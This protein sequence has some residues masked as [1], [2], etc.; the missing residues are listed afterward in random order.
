[1][2]PN[3][4]IDARCIWPRHIY[5]A[6]I[7]AYL[8][9]QLTSCQQTANIG[10]AT[11]EVTYPNGAK[12]TGTITEKSFFTTQYDSLLFGLSIGNADA[13]QGTLEYEFLQADGIDS[14]K[15]IVTRTL[16]LSGA[17]MKVN[18]IQRIQTP[19]GEF[20][21]DLNEVFLMSMEKKKGGGPGPGRCC[22]PAC[23]VLPPSCASCYIVDD[24]SCCCTKPCCPE[25]GCKP[26]SRVNLPIFTI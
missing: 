25:E 9:V 6:A 15:N 16:K 23:G 11:F 4:F 21:I 13:R 8:S 10:A 19:L 1:M 24:C 14:S 3:H 22:V 12:R 26:L 17:K 20:V 18:E 7:I 2:K 5:K